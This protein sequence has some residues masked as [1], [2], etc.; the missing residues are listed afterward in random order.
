MLDSYGFVCVYSLCGGGPRR[1]LA[2]DGAVRCLCG[3]L[4]LKSSASYVAYG[5]WM[6]RA[7]GTIQT[8]LERRFPHRHIRLE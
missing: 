4:L 7:P 6:L 5:G 3:M 2:A 1:F 8:Y